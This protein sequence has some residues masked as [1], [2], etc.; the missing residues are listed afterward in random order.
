MVGMAQLPQAVTY[1]HGTQRYWIEGGTIAVLVI[2]GAGRTEINE[3]AHAVYDIIQEAGD[4]SNVFIITHTENLQ[5]LTPAVR[6]TVN[7][8]FVGMPTNVH[9]TSAII[10]RDSLMHN[11]LNIFL[12][13]LRRILKISL[14]YRTFRDEA[15]AIEWLKAMQAKSA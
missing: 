15:S 11:L 8:F 10:L 2:K 6:Q 5:S 9:L 12:N 13:G 3:A 14:T 7:D 1:P 4:A